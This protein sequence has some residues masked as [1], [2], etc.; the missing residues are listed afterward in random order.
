[1]F[2][3]N[4]QD[5]LAYYFFKIKALKIEVRASLFRFQ[6]AKAALARVVTNKDNSIEV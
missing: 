5:P 4:G 6:E 2:I 1:M 3:S